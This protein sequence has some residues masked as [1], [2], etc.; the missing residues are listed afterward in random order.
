[1]AG[2]KIDK[3]DKAFSLYVRESQDW[4]CQRCGSKGETLANSHYFGRSNEAT[5]FAPENCDV[6]C[7]GCHQFWGSTDREAY[8]E[9]KIKQLGENGFKKLIILA[10]SYKKKDRRMSA[11][12]WTQAYYDLCKKKGRTPK[13]I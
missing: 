5:R 2:I 12:V 11:M 4:T 1:M 7:Y 3:A 10:N 9:F 6:L 8:R 13:R